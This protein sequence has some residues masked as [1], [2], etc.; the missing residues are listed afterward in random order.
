MTEKHDKKLQ[1][2]KQAS[3]ELKGR[4]LETIATKTAE[5]IDIAPLY[6]EADLEGLEHL[7]SLPGE[8]PFTRGPR[9]TMYTARP[10]TIRQYAG[11]ST[12]EETN[13]FF[14]KALKA[15]QK[16]CLLLLILQRIEAMIQIMHGYAVMWARLAWPLTQLRI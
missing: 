4:D 13:K 7:G 9:A 10:W 6:T 11:F 12:A 16:A 8:A 3:A 1:W 2:A 14:H 5:G 15:G